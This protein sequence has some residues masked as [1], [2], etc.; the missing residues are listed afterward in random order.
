MYINLEKQRIQKENEERR[1]ALIEKRLN[2]TIEW[3]VI[4]SG[5]IM[6]ISQFFIV[7]LQK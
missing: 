6:V 4:I 7:I 3:L 2:T 5:V 1:E